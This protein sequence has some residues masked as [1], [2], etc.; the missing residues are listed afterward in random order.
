SNSAHFIGVAVQGD[1][2]QPRGMILSVPYA[3][4]AGNAQTLAGRAPNEFV[5][6]N[7]LRDSVKSTLKAEGIA[8]REPTTS[9]PSTINRIAKFTDTANATG[10]SNMIDIGGNI[11]IGTTVPGNLLTVA[12]TASGDGILLDG[13]ANPNLLLA[14]SGTVRGRLA[15]ATGSN[16][17]S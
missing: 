6:S 13:S 1:A 7:D 11:G 9:A 12:P 16:A 4:A 3:A 15:L 10:D 2:E 8:P 5:L 14:N 17:F